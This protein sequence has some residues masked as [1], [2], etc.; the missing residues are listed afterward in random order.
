MSTLLHWKAARLNQKDSPVINVVIFL[1]NHLCTATI[2]SN[3]FSKSSFLVQYLP[4]PPACRQSSV[5]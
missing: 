1:L 2:P 3:T 5:F 4:R